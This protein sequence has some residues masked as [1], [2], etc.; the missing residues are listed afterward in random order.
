MH[1]RLI[2]EGNDVYAIGEIWK[3]HFPIPEGFTKRT[4]KDF[5]KIGTG[6]L[7]AME[8]FEAALESNTLNNIGI[9]VDADFDGI[10]GGVT[11]RWLRIKA[12]IEKRF[13]KL[14]LNAY[15]PTSEGIV[16]KKENYPTI[17]IWIMP[18]NQKD[19]YLEHF[20]AEMIA[21]DDVIYKEASEK[22]KKLYAKYPTKFNT[23]RQQ[24]HN[25]YTWLAWQEEPG[26]SFGTAI[27]Q[28]TLKTDNIQ[29]FRDWL[30]ATFLL[31]NDN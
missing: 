28:G 12:S 30:Q 24:K 11:K 14:D 23:L 19:G 15:H 4:E 18:N 3:K 25:L 1:Q 26:Q 31:K 2:L 9:V 17:G 10:N 29:A 27:R 6:F 13:P 21:S 8:L 20:L 16:I 5:A 22:I 7:G